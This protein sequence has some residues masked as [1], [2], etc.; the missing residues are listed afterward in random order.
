[1][2]AVVV[3]IG[4]PNF[5]DDGAGYEVVKRIKGRVAACHLLSPSFEIL[6]K[7]KGYDLGFIVDAVNFGKRSGEILEFTLIKGKS[8]QR[9]GGPLHTLSVE[10]IISTGYEVMDSLMPKKV[11][12]L[13][14]QVGS[15]EFGKELT[16]PVKEGVERIVKRIEKLIN[17]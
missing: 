3:G 11:V 14:V 9:Y 12:F 2:R 10:E 17:L 5:G 15:V 16:P 13:G 4:N 7:I 1:M 8:F 6:E